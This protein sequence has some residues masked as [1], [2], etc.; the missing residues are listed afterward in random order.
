MGLADR[1]AADT[2]KF[3]NPQDFGTVAR[4]THD[5]APTK[6]IHGLFYPKY[7]Q[8]DGLDYQ[9]ANT[10]PAFAAHSA[11]VEDVESGD[12]IEIN[13]VTYYVIDPQEDEDGMRLLMLSEHPPH[14]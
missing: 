1:L 11:D 14:G 6:R 7:E 5:G 4:Y 8:G 12:E 10:A 9:Q 13:E 3:T 2:A